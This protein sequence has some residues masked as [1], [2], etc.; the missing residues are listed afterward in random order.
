MLLYHTNDL[1]YFILYLPTSL[2]LIKYLE[3]NFLRLSILN[4]VE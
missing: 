1:F 4:D 2:I 3:V